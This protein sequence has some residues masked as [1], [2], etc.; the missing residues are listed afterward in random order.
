[1]FKLWVH[2]PTLL[3]LLYD[4]ECGRIKGHPLG[5]RHWLP[6]AL[7][8]NIY[9][10]SCRAHHRLFTKSKI[11]SKCW[12]TFKKPREEDC[13]INNLLWHGGDA[14]LLVR[15]RVKIKLR[16]LAIMTSQT[17]L[18]FSVSVIYEM[19]HSCRVTVRWQSR[20]LCFSFFTGL[21]KSN[22]LFQA[23]ARGLPPHGQPDKIAG[24]N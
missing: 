7:Q 10:L 2:W 17:N 11:F 19:I 23:V 1:M 6:T 5:W 15:P 8:P 3:L 20:V 12:N 4:V 9:T 18:G 21:A 22:T 16:L 13:P 14:T 24:I